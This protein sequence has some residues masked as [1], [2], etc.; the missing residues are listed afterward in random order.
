MVKNTDAMILQK[1]MEIIE[2]AKSLYESKKYSDISIL[3]IS[4]NCSLSRASIYNYFQSK[5]EIFLFLLDLEFKEWLKD[6]E[7]CQNNKQNLLDFAHEIARSLKKRYLML[8]LLSLHVHEIEE[9]CSMEALSDFKKTFNA[10]IF[11]MRKLLNENFQF[12]SLEA[13][14]FIYGFFP[15]LNGIYPYV[16]PTSRQNEAVSHLNYQIQTQTIYTMVYNQIISLMKGTHS[17]IL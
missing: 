4:K 3:E 17:Y 2:T 10:S 14:S 16:H 9:K 5:E 11:C 13:D 1:R 12:D 6:L 8:K 15:Y 7:S